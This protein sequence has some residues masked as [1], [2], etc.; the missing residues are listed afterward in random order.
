MPY[1]QYAGAR[2]NT[3]LAPITMR[4]SRSQPPVARAEAD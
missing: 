3:L 2:D 4:A 1:M